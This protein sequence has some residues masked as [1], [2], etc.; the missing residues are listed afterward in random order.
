MTI[1]SSIGY[2][3]KD[4]IF[5]RG[6]SL[7]RELMG[8]L[9]FTQMCLLEITGEIPSP[10][11]K[12]MADAMFVLLSDHGIMPSV[13]SARM[14]LLGAPEAIQGAVAAGVLG[15]GNHF[16][17]T[18]QNA[19]E[20][21]QSQ[22][23]RNVEIADDELG[24]LARGVIAQYSERKQPIPGLGHPLHKNGDP[25][26]KRLFEI[27]SEH[28]FYRAHCRLLVR[29]QELASQERGKFVPLN[30]AGAVGAVVS[31]IGWTPVMARALS[32]IARVPGL[33]AHIVEE[34]ENPQANA[35]WD[36]VIRNSNAFDL[37]K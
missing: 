26:S 10:E 4:E 27:A 8:K 11:V 13:I 22:T 6:R 5:V 34:I 21:L 3:T 37:E 15:A 23:A 1:E 36:L 14:T 30:A 7:T 32:L 29:I 28:G 35:M 20:M 33:L 9:D 17:G 19:A 24:G 31:D 12:A 18:T 16:L 2:S 25:R